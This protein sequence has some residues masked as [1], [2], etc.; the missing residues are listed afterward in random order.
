VAYT[1]DEVNNRGKKVTSDEQSI[2]NKLVDG[3]ELSHEEVK[4]INYSVLPLNKQDV[5]RYTNAHSI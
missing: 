3:L 2:L 4:L 5:H 1:N